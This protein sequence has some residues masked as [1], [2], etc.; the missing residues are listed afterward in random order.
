MLETGNSG[1]ALVELCGPI[2]NLLRVAYR[3]VIVIFPILESFYH[4][5]FKL[6]KI[7]Q[8][9]T[10]SPEFNLTHTSTNIRRRRRRRRPRRPRG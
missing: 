4:E 2:V 5:N 7:L 8:T 10:D 3:Q 9:M 6:G 1:E